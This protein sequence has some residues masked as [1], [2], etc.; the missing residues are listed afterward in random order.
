MPLTNPSQI[1]YQNISMAMKM[2]PEEK[3]VSENSLMGPPK[4]RSESMQQEDMLSP[5]R[6]VASYIELIQNKREE[7]KNG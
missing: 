1:A 7:L 6:R 3:T 2:K 4:K 5:A